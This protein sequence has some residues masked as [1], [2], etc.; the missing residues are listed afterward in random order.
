MVAHYLDIAPCPCN[1]TNASKQIYCFVLLA[2]LR[3][4]KRQ[5]QSGSC[6]LSTSAQT[7]ASNSLVSQL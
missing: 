5:L 4:I 6:V 1:S 3:A 7:P 2:R